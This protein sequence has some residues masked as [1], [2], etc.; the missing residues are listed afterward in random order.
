MVK[1]ASA[2]SFDRKPMYLV[3]AF[4]LFIG[5]LLFPTPPSLGAAGQVSLAL[6]VLAI[7][8][9]VS[10]C[11]SAPTS[12]VILAAAA[13]GGLYGKPL[14]VA[15]K[16]PLSTTAALNEMLSG[17]S[18]SAVILVAGALFLAAALKAT[19][20][21]RRLALLV[22][23]KVG[24]SPAR[25]IIGAILIGFVLA[26]FVPSATARVG[27]VIPIMLG[28]VA[29]LS[30][31]V[32]SSLGAALMIVS[33]EACS[34]F[35]I[36]IKTGAAQ[37]LIATDFMQKAFGHNIAWGDWF[38]TAL[39]F[40]VIMSVVLFLLAL[41]LLRPEV[42][43]RGAAEELLRCQ[44]AE[45]G[46]MTG[47]EKRLT[48]LAV[49]L[50][51]LW[52]T[53][54]KLHPIDS[55]SA[56][57][58]GVALLLMPGIG[59]LRWKTAEPLIPWGTVILFSIGISLGTLLTRTGAATWLANATLGQ[60][61]LGTLS[62][63]A[64]IAALSAFNIVLHLGFASATGLAS[65]LIPVMI[66]FAQQLPPST[67]NAFGIVLIQQF[68]VSIGFIL[69]MNAPQNMLCYGTGAFDTRTFA[70]IGVPLTIAGYL[71]ILALSATVWPAMGVL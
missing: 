19:G 54:G 71:V 37:N 46:P 55:T 51:V 13:V 62:A 16:V 59:V 6:L 60:L 26:L 22:M 66:A 52:A 38:M 48:A 28:I 39:P 24:V 2:A 42:P 65:T 17:F 49:V 29:A 8:L 18:S 41:F 3:L 5:V 32:N 27:A 64:V 15:S 44:L 14:N 35:A 9:W 43:E 50:L 61:G 23:S 40:T 30:L 25:L 11:V 34:I 1:N 68:V 56:M 36:G 4:A 10:E 31:P 69:P 45:L 57:V 21:D 12:A 70:L 67:G 33:A 20:L 58:M 47:S 7:T 63:V 53:E